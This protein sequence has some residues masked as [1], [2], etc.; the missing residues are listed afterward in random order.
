MRSVS[1]LRSRVGERQLTSAFC[2]R[3]VGFLLYRPRLVSDMISCHLSSFN[4][5][6]MG[7]AHEKLCMLAKV[8]LGWEVAHLDQL[9]AI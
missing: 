6:K 4:I 9:D 1:Q 3:M 5:P 8:S 7:V 2:T